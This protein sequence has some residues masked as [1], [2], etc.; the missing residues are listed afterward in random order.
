MRR[1]AR[2]PSFTLFA[3]T[4]L[5]RNGHRAEI[6]SSETLTYP[7]GTFLMWSGRCVECGVALRWLGAGRGG[8][9]AK[10]THPFDLVEL[11]SAAASV[12]AA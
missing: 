6:T 7:S 2:R 9:A 12:K 1:K 8:Y 11:I 3:G 4:W 10:G 5:M